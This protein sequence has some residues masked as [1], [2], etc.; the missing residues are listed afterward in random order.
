MS[1]RWWKAPSPAL[2]ISLIALFVALGGTTYAA[3]SLPKN[4]VGTAQLKKGAVTKQKISKKTIGALRGSRGPQ[5]PKGDQGIQGAKGDQGIQG[6]KGDTGPRG[7]SDAYSTTT[8]FLT[9]PAGNYVVQAKEGLT[10][11]T[12][13]VELDCT[14]Y[15]TPVG[16]SL[17]SVDRAETGST[18]ASGTTA[19]V[20]PLQAVVNLPAGGEIS[21]GCA[22]SASGGSINFDHPELSAIQVGATH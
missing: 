8:P 10:G 14:L 4:S 21:T 11:G 19:L 2:V 22:G 7:P 15:A 1:M 9:V 18:T 20:L 12:G 17:T 13:A 16:G 5:G 6:A 3:T